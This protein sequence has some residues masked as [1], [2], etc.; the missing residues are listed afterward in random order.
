MSY[1][2]YVL[3]KIQFFYVLKQTS[4]DFC[5]FCL[6]PVLASLEMSLSE[7]GSKFHAIISRIKFASYIWARY[8]I[9]FS[10]RASDAL[11]QECELARLSLGLYGMWE[12]Q[13]CSQIFMT[14]SLEMPPKLYLPP[15]KNVQ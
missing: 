1:T 2:Y 10:L 9:S 5:E 4:S 14:Q 3:Q 7:N 15:M 13:T 8:Q 12:I 11:E 6:F